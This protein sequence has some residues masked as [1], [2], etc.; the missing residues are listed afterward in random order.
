MYLCSY[1][2][3]SSLTTLTSLASVTNPSIQSQGS[4]YF[5]SFIKLA[6]FQRSNLLSD[7]IVKAISL[8]ISISSQVVILLSTYHI[9]FPSITHSSIQLAAKGVI[10]GIEYQASMIL[11][12]N[13][14]PIRCIDNHTRIQLTSY[15]TISV[16]VSYH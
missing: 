11:N 4:I 6:Y 1:S 16:K 13:S 15:G 9:P 7:F 14:L 5:L 12:A 2:C 10:P 3:I 8:G